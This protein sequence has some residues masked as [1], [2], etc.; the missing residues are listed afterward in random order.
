[1]WNHS[2]ECQSSIEIIF[3]TQDFA[4]QELQPFAAEWDRKQYFPVQT[5][6]KAADL[7]FGGIFCSPE[8]G[9]SK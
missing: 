1:M 4:R 6:R 9:G 5:I 8:F 2:M 7:G 3:T